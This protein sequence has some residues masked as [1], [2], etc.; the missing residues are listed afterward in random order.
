M[1]DKRHYAKRDERPDHP[2]PIRLTERDLQIVQTVYAYRVLTTQQLQALFFPSAHQ[3]YAR[4]SL[5]YQHGYLDRKF[6]GAYLDKMNRSVLYVLDKRGAELLRAERGLDVEWS[7]HTKQVGLPF[8]E[9]TLAINT[10]RVAI[11]QAC[12]QNPDFAVL[13]WRS[14]GDLKADYDY[15]SIR[16][17]MGK[18]MSVSVIP[19]SY[20]V[21]QT[22]RG[23]AHFFLEQDMGS[24]TT[25]R[26]KQ[27]ILA[28]QAY[29]ANGLYEKRYQTKSLRVLTITSSQAR[30]DSLLRST[31][32]AGGK[33][34][35]WFTTLAQATPDHILT[36]PIWQVAQKEGSHLLIE[37]LP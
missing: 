7:S 20:F 12:Q 27:K 11:V 3:A 19:D 1:P 6:Q 31:E 10:V 14:E 28:Y 2:K 34:R 25:K 4:L 22:P 26:F 24:M 23:I 29:Y 16:S 9:H 5:L 21:L 37:P 36:A 32:E 18:T 17:E 30:V 15:V 33:Q 35:F 13:E 8:L